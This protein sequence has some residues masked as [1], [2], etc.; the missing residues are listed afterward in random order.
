MAFEPNVNAGPPELVPDSS[1]AGGAV[2]D[3]GNDEEWIEI[4]CDKLLADLP[5]RFRGPGWSADA[6]ADLVLSIDREGLLRRLSRGSLKF[7]LGDLLDAL[8]GG[9]LQGDPDSVLTLD[10]ASV[11]EVLPPEIFQAGPAQ[12]ATAAATL[13][14]VPNLFTPEQMAGGT[15]ETVQYEA[16]HVPRSM[17]PP[18]AASVETVQVPCQTLLANLPT[19]LRGENWQKTAFPNT[20]L[21]LNRDDLMNRLESGKLVFRLGPFLDQ[22]PDGWVTR[23][24]EALVELDLA[25]VVATVPAE[26]FQ[27]D[28]GPEAPAGL[29]D[30]P[31]L[32]GG[33][34]DG[35]PETAAAAVARPET[36]HPPVRKRDTSSPTVRFP[37]SALLAKLP[38]RLRGK[39]WK[40]DAFP[41]LAL[42][43]D[44]ADLLQ[45]LE[46]GKLVYRLDQF[47]DAL[48]AAWIQA[49][50]DALVEIDLASVV[51]AIP[52]E[53]L[54][55]ATT[56]PPELSEAAGLPNLFQPA[57]ATTPREPQAAAAP[58]APAPEPA[59]APAPEPALVAPTAAPPAE[60]AVRPKTPRPAKTAAARR[61]T[62]QEPVW[63]GVD[64]SI[65]SAP[66]GIDI[67]MATETELALL[68]QIGTARAARIVAHRQAHGPFA[69]VFELVNVPGIGSTRFRKLT[70]L[71]L[72]TRANRCQALRRLLGTQEQEQPLLRQITA[73]LTTLLAV[74]GCLLTNRDGIPLGQATGALAEDANRY[75]ALAA[76][77]LFKTRRFFRQFV[78]T[79]ADSMILPANDPPLLL[80]CSQ[81]VVIIAAMKGKS[82]SER[83]LAL[84]RR[85]I[86]EIGWL[87]SRRAVVRQR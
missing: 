50:P 72:R 16:A 1:D 25:A 4:P 39:R 2:P 56:A 64:P 53:L 7:K 49:D 74:E 55:P 46:S 8:P 10:V 77:F 11:V 82:L 41:D 73:A 59:P 61:Q 27:P 23:D 63:P 44:Q 51:E 32:F 24:P 48:P 6:L 17:R 36:A 60:A 70:G 19:R 28:T 78:G 62:S 43:V 42:E 15:D 31:D 34:D 69:S 83:R 9:W 26:M 38:T 87:L 22:L 54:T 86:R 84:A 80:L 58:K 81:D 35:Q 47:L 33:P 5:P 18:E 30:I 65:E 12:P 66:A 13:D 75:A 71:S 67:N 21:T 52:P 57:T 29:D 85:A 76:N 79:A 40:P 3:A 20:K 68:P 14:D 45:R 37:C